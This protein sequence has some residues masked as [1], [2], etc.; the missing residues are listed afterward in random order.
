M[1]RV[2]ILMLS[3]LVGASGCVTAHQPSLSNAAMVPNDLKPGDTALITVVVDDRFGLVSEVNGLVQ[4]DKTITFIF[5]DDGTKGDEKAGDSIWSTKVDVPFNA[6]PGGFT[7]EISAYDSNG[8]PIIVRDENNEVM[9]MS[10]SFTLD[11]TYP[12]A[13]EAE[14]VEEA[15]E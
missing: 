10:T 14:E 7:F 5:R 6:P 12:E 9:R 3:L 2:Y 13:E 1:Q 11:I 15:A 8:N 4:G